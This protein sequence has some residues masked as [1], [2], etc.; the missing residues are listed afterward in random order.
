MAVGTAITGTAAGVPFLVVPPRVERADA[1][2]VVAWHLMDPPR[3][4]AAF[5]AALPLAGL[6]AWRVYLGLP[7][8]G[9]RFPEGGVEELMRRGYEDAVLNLYGPVSAQAADEFGPAFAELRERFGL[10]GGPVGL[11]GGSL[12]AAVAQLVLASRAVEV[13][14]AVL[15][16]PVSRLESVVAAVGRLFGVEYP[17]SEPSL[18]VARRLDFVARA[19]E[20]AACPATLLVVGAEDDEEGFRQPAARLRDALVQRSVTTDLVVVPGMGHALAEEPGIEPAPQLPAAAEVDRLA[21]DWFTRHL[22]CER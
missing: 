11:L 10:R 8:H 20:V 12:G 22:G 5:A 1:P 19:A 17:W 21:V 15:V 13:A 4:E 9:A 3:T 6:D 14:A 2:V 18:E 16:S 7:L